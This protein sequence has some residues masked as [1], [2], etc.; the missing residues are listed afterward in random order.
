MSANLDLHYTNLVIK[1]QIIPNYS[2]IYS[3][4]N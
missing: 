3:S 4:T 2:Y 1:K